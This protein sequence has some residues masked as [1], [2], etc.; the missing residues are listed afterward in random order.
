MPARRAEL[1]TALLIDPG[2]WWYLSELARAVG[3]TASSLQ[4]DLSALTAADIL[5]RRQDGNRV[6]YR[7]HPGCPLLPELRGLI[8]KT[9]GVV[10]VLREAL[11]PMMK[12]IRVAFVFGSVAR[13]EADSSSDVDLLVVG[14]VGHVDLVEPLRVA[15]DR[16]G[17]PVN[18]C[19][20]PPA[21]FEQKVAAGHY[22]LKTVLGDDKLFV[23]GGE[24]ELGGP[25]AEGAGPVAPG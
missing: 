4:R 7:A 3:T 20:F 8:A 25:A 23:I 18:P 22:F 21:E 17:R 6:Y 13:G 16:L 11:A 5:Q 10:G 14:D 19:V 12:R 1:L 15:G 9:T 2:R 24:D